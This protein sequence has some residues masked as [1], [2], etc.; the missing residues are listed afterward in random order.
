M[1]RSRPGIET[2]ILA[3]DAITIVQA[4]SSGSY[5]T[6]DDADAGLRKAE[7]MRKRRR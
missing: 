5:E 1:W 6:P 7:W 4:I 2:E 3:E